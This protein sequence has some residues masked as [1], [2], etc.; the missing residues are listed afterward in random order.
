MSH[1]A[2]LENHQK[3]FTLFGYNSKQKVNKKYDFF[4][5]IFNIFKTGHFP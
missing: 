3:C 1:K 5:V 4:E 2:S